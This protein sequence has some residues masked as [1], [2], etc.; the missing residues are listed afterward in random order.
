MVYILNNQLDIIY[1]L[2]VGLWATIGGVLGSA[3][4][5]IYIKMKGRQSTIIFVLVLEFVVAAVLIPYFG[6]S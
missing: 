6:V 5:I 4:L 2:W 3:A 1:S